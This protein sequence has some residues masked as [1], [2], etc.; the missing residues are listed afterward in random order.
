MFSTLTVAVLF[1]LIVGLGVFGACLVSAGLE[2]RHTRNYDV[3]HDRRRGIADM[4]TVGGF[5]LVVLSVVLFVV[6]FNYI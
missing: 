1:L 2:V 5:A 6:A 3:P 4:F